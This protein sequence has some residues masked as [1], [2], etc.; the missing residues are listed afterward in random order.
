[1]KRELTEMG[2]AKK[3]TVLNDYIEDT[4]SLFKNIADEMSESRVEWT[5]LNEYFKQL[6]KENCS[7]KSF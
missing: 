3:V 1:M 6:V 4:L 7:M 5:E 2:M